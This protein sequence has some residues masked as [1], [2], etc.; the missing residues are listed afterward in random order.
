MGNNMCCIDPS[1]EKY[2]EMTDNELLVEKEENNNNR[3]W[4]IFY[5]IGYSLSII[6]PTIIVICGGPVTIL[7]GIGV[8]TFA[9]IFYIVDYNNNSIKV[10][11]I[12]KELYKRADANIMKIKKTDIVQ[13]N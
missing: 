12:E 2:R 13:I 11:T 8:S 9:L 7:I 10:E 4:D 1:N 5:C 6:V 3:K